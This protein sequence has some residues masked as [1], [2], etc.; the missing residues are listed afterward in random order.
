MQ[1]HGRS[2]RIKIFEAYRQSFARAYI[3]VRVEEMKQ[4]LEKARAVNAQMKRFPDD[5]W[6]HG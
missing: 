1:T 4:Q 3:Y 5:M 2:I 6:G